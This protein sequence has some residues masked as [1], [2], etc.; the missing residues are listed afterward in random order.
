ML[1]AGVAVVLGVAGYFGFIWMR[2]L[3]MLGNIDSAIVRM[4][5]LYTAENQ[6][7]K[8]HPTLGYTCTLSQLPPSDEIQRLV[9]RNR[10]ENGYAFEVA[11]C[12]ARAAERPNST[13]SITARPL[14]S[15]QPAFC[16]DQSGIIKADYGGSVEGCRANGVPL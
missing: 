6:F 11:G 15:G 1:V 8:A 14:H 10:I 4:R 9:A 13:Y 16:S 12:A 3:M 2:G 7:A 5:L